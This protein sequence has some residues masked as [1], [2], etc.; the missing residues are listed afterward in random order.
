MR[1]R[2]ELSLQLDWRHWGLPFSLTFLS[3]P[4]AGCLH[5]LPL[6]LGWSRVEYDEA[7]LPGWEG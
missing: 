6:A 2:Y 5:F 7:P 1:V 3:F 4:T